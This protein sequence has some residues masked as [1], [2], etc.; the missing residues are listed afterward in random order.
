MWTQVR[1]VA[2]LSG[3]FI[4]LSPATKLS[5]TSSPHLLRPTSV[6]FLCCYINYFSPCCDQTPDKSN[7]R[8]EGRQA[9]FGSQLRVQTIMAGKSRPQEPEVTGHIAYAVR[10]KRGMDARTQLAFSF[11]MTL[12]AFKVGLPHKL[13]QAGKAPHK[14]TQR[15]IS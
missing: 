3:L 13:I 14:C 10:K 12:P 11:L 6:C 8:K 9:Y 2:L 4:L 1:V 15:F 5:I 7:P